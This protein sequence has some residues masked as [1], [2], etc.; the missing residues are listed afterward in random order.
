MVL[1]HTL[2]SQAGWLSVFYPYLRGSDG[3]ELNAH[4]APWQHMVAPKW[5][6]EPSELPRTISSAPVQWDYFGNHFDLHFHAGSLGD[7]IDEATGAVRPVSCWIVTHDPPA[8]PGAKV[9]H[10][11]SLADALELGHRSNDQATEGLTV[12]QRKQ[13][14]DIH[15]EIAR[16]EKTVGAR[17][18]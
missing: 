7:E 11:R 12:L 14:D 16:L 6:P 3:L 4:L 9:A 17:G 8:N 1:A 13:I 2:L 5:G 15:T 18:N 10:L